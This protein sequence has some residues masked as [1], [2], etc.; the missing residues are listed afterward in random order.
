MY[1]NISGGVALRWEIIF[2]CNASIVIKGKVS[3]FVF[4][5]SSVLHSYYVKKIR[6]T[7][8]MVVKSNISINSEVRKTARRKRKRAAARPTRTAESDY[9][10]HYI[11]G[12]SRPDHRDNTR[13][14]NITP[15]NPVTLLLK[16]LY[17][18]I[19]F[20]NIP[21]LLVHR[22]IVISGLKEEYVEGDIP[23]QY[24]GCT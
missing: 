17:M 20:W 23:T 9:I 7:E 13:T 15:V 21:R 10:C 4:K 1:G 5:I 14:T 24:C 11:Q 16:P 3:K 22:K 8:K 19:M 18:T 2:Q 12:P 6:E